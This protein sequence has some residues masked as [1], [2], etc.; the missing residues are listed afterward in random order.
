MYES[1]WYQL[2]TLGVKKFPTAAP[3]EIELTLLSNK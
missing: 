1:E 2:L 3:D